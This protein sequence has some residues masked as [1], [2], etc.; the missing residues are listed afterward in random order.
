[1]GVFTNGLDNGLIN[2]LIIGLLTCFVAAIMIGLPTGF[3]FV[4]NS[5]WS[6]YMIATMT[7][8]RRGD[9]PKRPAV[10]LDWAYEAGLI[11]LS[12]VA[13]QFRH[14][15]FQDWLINRSQPADD[16]TPATIGTGPATAGGAQG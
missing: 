3:V 12:G 13:V 15:E 8:A 2:G 14:R 16:H 9:L 1:M 6:R 10:F 4:A 7:L 11:R 5:S